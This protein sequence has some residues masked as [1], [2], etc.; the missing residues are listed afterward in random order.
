MSKRKTPQTP[1]SSSELDAIAAQCTQV[2]D[3]TAVTLSRGELRQYTAHRRDVATRSHRAK[4]EQLA[5]LRGDR[6]SARANKAIQRQLDKVQRW[7]RPRRIRVAMDWDLM[8]KVRFKQQRVRPPAR[9]HLPKYDDVITDRIGRVGVFVDFKYDGAKQNK[10]RVIRRRIIYLL[11]P[12]HCEKDAEGR[13]IATCNFGVLREEVGAGADLWELAQRESRTDAQLCKNVIIQLPHDLSPE[14]RRALMK[15]LAHELFGRHGLPYVA[16]VHEPDPDGDQRNYHAHICGG[17]RPMKR[18]GF[19][20]WDIAEDYRSDLDGPKYLGD[21]RRVIAE[22]MTGH[23]NKAGIERIYTHLSNAERGLIHRPQRKLDKRK[24]RMA[25]E[26]KFVADVEANGEI[27]AANQHAERNLAAKRKAISEQIRKARASVIKRITEVT[28]AGVSKVTR[29]V[30]VTMPKSNIMQTTGDVLHVAALNIS[31][32]NLARPRSVVQVAQVSLA[33]VKPPVPANAVRFPSRLITTP[34]RAISRAGDGRLHAVFRPIIV[35]MPPTGILNISAVQPAEVK[36]GVNMPTTVT[37]PHLWGGGS[38]SIRPVPMSKP[39]KP[40]AEY[41]SVSF[42]YARAVSIAAVR[43]PK[44]AMSVTTKPVTTPARAPAIRVAPVISAGH[45]GHRVTAKPFEFGGHKSTTINVAAVSSVAHC[46]RRINVKPVSVL[47]VRSARKVS[48]FETAGPVRATSSE[49]LEALLAEG[50]AVADKVGLMLTNIARPRSR[51]LGDTATDQGGSGSSAQSVAAREKPHS[52]LEFEVKAA[53]AL[54]EKIP[55]NAVAIPVLETKSGRYT[56]AANVRRLHKLKTPILQDD[57]VQKLLQQIERDQTSEMLQLITLL[58]L[59]GSAA[60]L[61]DEKKAIAVLPREDQAAALRWT[62]TENFQAV[63]RS[64]KKR[65]RTKVEAKIAAW[66]KANA[67][68]A[69]DRYRLAS[70]AINACKRWAVTP[71]ASLLASMKTDAEKHSPLSKF[72]SQDQDRGR[73]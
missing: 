25:R 60:D 42:P 3:G 72:G 59:H 66:S 41:E 43:T 22:I 19:G 16:S 55:H 6:I 40:I 36:R 26:G 37:A 8:P 23:V 51:P 7:Y 54:L 1:P 15:A 49:R 34:I 39:P 50:Q 5:A 20:E 71:G 18:T 27:I 56:I 53:L 11:D 46:V 24:V 47:P 70:I 44:P 21:A 4:R 67:A 64:V 14:E 73:G 35:A 65:E 2:I 32:V 48:V 68:Q 28:V 13:P 52:P 29:A 57:R 12:A 31:G 69:V 17:L 61:E 10:F 58:Q 45:L 33:F 62:N 63:I 30:S 38:V 9:F